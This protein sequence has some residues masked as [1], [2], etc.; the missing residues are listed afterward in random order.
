[1]RVND[2]LLTADSLAKLRTVDD[3]L[4]FLFFVVVWCGTLGLISCFDSDFDSIADPWHFFNCSSLLLLSY[5]VLVFLSLRGN[6]HL[7]SGPGL[8]WVPS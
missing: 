8:K 5:V 2:G 4:L 7:L 1:M 3:A 6:P